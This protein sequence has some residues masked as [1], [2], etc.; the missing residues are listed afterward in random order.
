MKLLHTADWHLGR[1]LNGHRLIEDQAHVLDRFVEIVGA[2]RPDL[3]V[4]AGDVYDRAVPPPDAVSL[5]DDV[6][7]RIV[8]GLGVPVLAIAGNHD[9]PERFHFASRLLAG[10]RLH[11]RGVFESAPA[12]LCLEDRHGPVRVYPVPFADPPVVRERLADPSI[13]GQDA[14]FAAVVGAIR[15]GHPAGC[16]AVLAAHAFVVGGAGSDS[17]R[18]LSVGGTGAVDAAHFAGFDYVALGHLHRPQALGGGGIHYAGSLLKY[19]TSEIDHLKSVTLVE[20]GASGV[21]HNETI[22]LTPRRDLRRIEGGIDRLLAEP[23]PGNREDYL[24]VRLLDRGVVLDAMARLRAVYPN[25]VE[26]ERPALLPAGE[27]DR[28]GR[29]HRRLGPVELFE[30]FFRYVTGDDLAED[31]RGAFAA[32]VTELERTGREGA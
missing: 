8:L 7:C 16:R 19:S 9:G 15:A 4:I 20:L 13:E 10:G 29:D 24:V 27:I 21:V 5:L 31:E 11:L 26:I 14:A 12:P 25:I 6:L 22:P 28:A 18:P 23:D 30:G 3:V 2:V 1:S 17:E 32:A